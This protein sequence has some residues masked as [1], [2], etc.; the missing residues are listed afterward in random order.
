MAN[1]EGMG[2]HRQVNE[3]V[4]VCVLR[5]LCAHVCFLC[6]RV[7]FSLPCAMMPR[8]PVRNSVRVLARSRCFLWA[9]RNEFSPLLARW[10]VIF[11]I[12]P[13]HHVHVRV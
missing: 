9:M 1:V 10:C 7:L 6:V 8:I 5:F 11:L 12:Y 2:L 4:C 13:E 3:R